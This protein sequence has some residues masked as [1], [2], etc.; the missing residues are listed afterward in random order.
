MD[1]FLNL[2]L[3]NMYNNTYK[4]KEN[5]QHFKIWMEIYACNEKK[6]SILLAANFGPCNDSLCIKP[7]TI[8]YF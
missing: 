7:H 8:S 6:S 1:G 2:L 4:L 3:G 5:S